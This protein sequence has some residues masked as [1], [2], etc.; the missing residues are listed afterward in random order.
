MTRKVTIAAVQLPASQDGHTIAERYAQNV[1]AAEH[2]LDEAG[3][4]GADIAC[5]GEMSNI[6]GLHLT[7]DRPADTGSRCPTAGRRAAGGHRAPA[8]HGRDC[9]PRRKNR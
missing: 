6:V 3:K 1:R 9:A 8:H 5:V 2:W 7:R 4:L